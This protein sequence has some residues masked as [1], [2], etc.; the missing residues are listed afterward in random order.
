MISEIIEYWATFF[1]VVL[2]LQFPV[3]QSVLFDLFALYL[4]VLAVIKSVIFFNFL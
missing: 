4:L 1:A 2:A 3:M